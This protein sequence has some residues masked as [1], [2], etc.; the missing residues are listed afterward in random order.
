MSEPTVSRPSPASCP[1]VLD[2]APAETPS[3]RTGR[4]ADIL[5]RMRSR[6]RRDTPHSPNVVHTR[7][8]CQAPG[9][10][11]ETPRRTETGEASVCPCQRP[12]SQGTAQKAGRSSGPPAPGRSSA[13]PPAPLPRVPRRAP[14]SDRAGAPRCVPARARRPGRRP[15]PADTSWGSSR[16]SSSRQP[17]RAAI[18]AAS[19][20]AAS[21]RRSGSVR[22]AG[23]W[24]WRTAT[25]LR[26]QGIP[27]RMPGASRRTSSA[28][29]YCAACRRKSE[30]L[31][32]ISRFSTGSMRMRLSLEDSARKQALQT[33]I[34]RALARP[35][36]G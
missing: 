24:R 4:M 1:P 16:V 36:S 19:C 12:T 20:Q 13:G 28:F 23:H 35:V 30:R 29:G 2:A 32:P 22:L 26:D 14:C 3:R 31:C 5:T 21:S 25:A 9:A 7:T 8:D 10:R 18:I 33:R 27:N 17:R 6:S 15:C 34:A 11:G